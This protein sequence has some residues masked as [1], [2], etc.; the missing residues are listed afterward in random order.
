MNAGATAL[1]PEPTT[2]NQSMGIG[3]G[4]D[5]KSDAAQGTT[6][7]ANRVQMFQDPSMLY[8]FREMQRRLVEFIKKRV[9]LLEKGLNAEYQ[10][11]YFVSLSARSLTYKWIVFT[12]FLFT[13]SLTIACFV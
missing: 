7:N 9:L 10:K 3:G 1:N 5:L 12:V 6:E 4:N 8:N 2:N 13:G 11:I